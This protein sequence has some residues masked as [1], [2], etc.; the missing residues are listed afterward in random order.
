MRDL[1]TLDV[2]I[3]SVYSRHHLLVRLLDHLAPQLSP[4]CGNARV[5]LCRD[6]GEGAVGSKRNRLMLAATARH[7]CFVDDDDRVA[8]VY[9]DRLM[10]ALA[11]DPDY[12]GFR[13]AYS[14]DGY[15]QKPAVHSLTNREWSETDTCYL[16]GISH[17]NPVRRT[18]AL[19][20]LP[21]QPGFGED[22]AWADRV[23]ASGTV[24]SE[25]YVPEDLYVYAYSSSGSLFRHG[26]KH[27][28]L[29]APMLPEYVNVREIA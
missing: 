17:L 28:G 26:P 12:V 16:R 21:F 8:D 11:T 19:L 3:A 7:V 10:E 27:T 13:V 9:V 23:A 20:G 1:P 6:D 5:I 15:P 29:P 14:V 4:Y 22:K 25:V 2:L 18:S 24:Q